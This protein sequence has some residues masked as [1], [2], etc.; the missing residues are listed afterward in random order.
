MGLIHLVGQN[1]YNKIFNYNDLNEFNREIIILENQNVLSLGT[2]RDIFVT[3]NYGNLIREL[4]E[5]GNLIWE[6]L[7]VVDSLS[8]Y[9]NWTHCYQQINDSILVVFSSATNSEITEFYPYYL[10]YNTQSN[11]I[12]NI[13][14]YEMFPMGAAIYSSVIHNDGYIYGAG[15]K[16]FN[17]AFEDLLI[18]K[19]D[20]EGNLIWSRTFDLGI[21]EHAFDIESFNDNLILSGQQ[22]GPLFDDTESFIMIIDSSGA[23][24]DYIEPILFGSSG[25]IATEIHNDEI[26]F[27]TETQVVN[28][29]GNSDDR[30][31]Y[32]AKFDAD[33]NIIW[34][35][36]IEKTDIYG[37][38]FRRME[39]LND[40][41]IIG[42]NIVDSL[43]LTNNK[44]WSYACSYDLDGNFNWEHVY[45]YDSTFTHHIDDIEVAENGDLIFMGTVITPL[46]NPLPQ[47]NLW[48]FRTDSD[49][50]GIVQDIC[51]SSIEDYFY[52]NSMLVSTDNYVMEDNL[53]SIHGNPFQVQL[54]FT[55]N[56]TITSNMHYEIFDM[57]GRLV[58]FDTVKPNNLIETSKWTAGFYVLAVYQENVL[59][60]KERLVKE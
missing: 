28:G 23:Q 57:H 60:G 30:I 36:T 8:M 43:Q 39:I 49:G 59:I 42:A 31:Q 16:D 24:L 48:L 53:I 12:I 25:I 6:D 44:V 1:H 47:Q 56:A 54:S 32:L 41:I 58:K 45:F 27:A 35:Q 40:E 2:A 9:S 29:D 19:L 5:F 7:I 14:I 26:Y 50:C 15:F 33:L 21:N 4:D 13:K 20:I 55:T 34:E 18:M 17:T 46:A 51:Y 37:I 52:S 10:K 3:G 38:N 11:Q 22:S